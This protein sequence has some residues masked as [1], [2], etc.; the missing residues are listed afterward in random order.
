M[1]SWMREANLSHV[2]RGALAEERDWD[3][4]R[5]RWA[6]VA[7]PV[8]EHPLEGWASRCGTGQGRRALSALARSTICTPLLLLLHCIPPSSFAIKPIHHM[9]ITT[10]LQQP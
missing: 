3:C 9:N 4:E 6:M 7:S 10:T 5:G 8:A 2:A 1:M